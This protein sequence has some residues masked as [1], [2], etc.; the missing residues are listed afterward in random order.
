MRAPATASRRPRLAA[1]ALLALLLVACGAPG[2]QPIV[3]HEDE[4]A[5]CRMTISDPRFAAQAVTATG[6]RH[7]FDSIEC[8]AAYV[9]QAREAG[10]VRAA[11]VTDFRHPGTFI[12]ADSARFLRGAGPGSPMGS[13]LLAVAADADL[14]ALR[15]E[16]GGEPLDW[17]A[18]LALA[19]RQTPAAPT[20]PGV[21]G[22]PADTHGGPGAP[23][24]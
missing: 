3:L 16:I 4:C 11:W 14:E 12:P 1:L 23:A 6:K 10:S 18:V 24:H 20:R 15:R 19:S 8:L 7:T 17:P 5:Y 13:G 21:P 2:P 22:A 9:G